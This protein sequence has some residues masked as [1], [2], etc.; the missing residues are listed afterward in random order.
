MTTS[1]G[2]LAGIRVIETTDEKGEFGARLLADLG[3]Q[4]TRV[5]PP[6][7]A[8][9]RRLPPFAP[10]GVTSLYFAYRNA[11]KRGVTLDIAQPEGQ[12]LLDR[13]LDDCDVWIESFAPGYLA[14]IGLDPK[15]VL[16]RHPR[17][18]LAS[19]T[20]FG[21][22]G[23]YRDYTGTDMVGFAT[24]GMMYRAG[25]PE[26]PPLVA[27]G[28][29]AYDSTG[30]T[31]AFA[32]LAACVRRA[33]TGRGQHVDVSVMES[34][35]NQ[36]DW[37]L[38]SY[39][40]TGGY[41]Q[42]AGTGPMY[43]LYH[44]SDGWVRMIILSP[45]QWLGIRDWLGEPDALK[46]EAWFSPMFRVMNRDVLDNF[47]NELFSPMTKLEAVKEAQKRGIVLTPVLTPPEVL[48]NEHTRARGTF[49]EA[50]VA[51]GIRGKMM[52][53][54][55]EIDGE[56]HGFRERAP[57][58]GEHNASVFGGELGLPDAELRRLRAAGVV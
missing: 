21:Q 39:S 52:A 57:T 41:Q 55:A 24:G 42:R 46:D 38:P 32:I 16:E 49:V 15:A 44:C 31:A 27:P 37:T 9:S 45:R 58:P 34:V 36:A 40:R 17:L 30:V 2:P 48:D 18:I 22:T 28:N 6:G 51:P 14:S 10:D 47:M 43:P 4:I 25:S 7:G 26:R 11:N 56:R 12:Q 3:A 53:G 29:L 20:G 19:I 50:A 1:A 35:A 23:P 33:A 8:G 13:L 5:E 54:V